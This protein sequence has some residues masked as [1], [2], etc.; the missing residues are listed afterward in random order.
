MEFEPSFV[1]FTWLHFML[2]LM[3]GGFVEA[4]MPKPPP[5]DLIA[6]QSLADHAAKMHR[7]KLPVPETFLNKRA[8]NLGGPEVDIMSYFELGANPSSSKLL[9]AREPFSSGGLT[10]FKSADIHLSGLSKFTAKDYGGHLSRRGPD[11]CLLM[12][13]GIALEPWGWT[14]DTYYANAVQELTKA[15]IPFD[16]A[17]DYRLYAAQVTGGTKIGLHAVVH[18]YGPT[19]TCGLA[20]YAANTR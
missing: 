1:G 5:T 16:K 4:I 17:G 18:N 7:D 15:N 6:L 13:L 12:A 10:G 3:H 2:S 20:R 9:T 11:S 14:P 8:R 19:E